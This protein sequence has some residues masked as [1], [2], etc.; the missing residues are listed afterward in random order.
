M[1]IYLTIFVAIAA[2]L[3]TDYLRISR[4]G[5]IACLLFPFFLLLILA[6]TR[7][8]TGNDWGPYHDYFEQLTAFGDKEQD[9]EFG[10]RLSSYL[11]K[12]LGAGYP[13]FVFTF[14]FA[15]LYLFFGVFRKQTGAMALVLLFFTTYLL[16]WMGTARQVM[17]IALTVC[18]GQAL[19]EKKT[20]TFLI[21]VVTASLFHQTAIIFLIASLL[22]RDLKKINFYIYVLVLSIIGGQV[23]K[24]ALPSII[25]V[26]AGVAGI[27]EQVIKYSNIGS[28]ELGHQAGQ[29]I[30]VL[31][32]AKRILFLTIFLFFIRRF[33]SAWLAFYFNAYILSVVLFFIISPTL[34]ILATRGSN[35]FSIYELFLLSSLMVSLAKWH[36]IPIFLIITLSGQR[37]YTSLYA[38]HPDLY[39]PYK[40]LFINETFKRE[41]Y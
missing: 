11:M 2:L 32:Y 25:D 29:F 7:I 31:W 10:Y 30:E 20:R 12:Q 40:G 4:G 18:A 13:T 28:E 35:Y 19:L 41:V 27:G 5:R 33:E 36:L 37:L 17:A 22:R 24:L 39:I 21:F 6:G 14:T 15:Y 38:Y 16:G 9:F 3:P 34:P 1:T 8:E 26:I 23:M